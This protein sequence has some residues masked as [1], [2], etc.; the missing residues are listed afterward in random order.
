MTISFK[1]I[2]KL[3]W[4]IFIA[5]IGVF[6]LSL[7]DSLMLAHSNAQHLGLQS[8]G[9][10]PITIVLMIVNGLVQGTL[11]AAAEYY[12]QEKYLEVGAIFRNSIKL[13]LYLSLIAIPLFLLAHPIL[14]LLNYPSDQNIAAARVMK[15]LSL[16]IPFSL[17]YFVCMFFLNGVQKPRIATEF[18]IIANLLNAFLNWLLIEGN[19]GFPAMYSSGVALSTTI[20]RIFLSI[21]LLL[22]ILFLPQFKKFNIIHGKTIVPPKNQQLLG[23]SA[24]INLLSFEIG[25]AFCLFFASH[26][27]LIPAAAFT[28]SYRIIAMTHLISVSFAVAASTYIAPLQN[29]SQAMSPIIKTTF[30]LNNLIIIPLVLL[31]I[32]ATYPLSQILSNDTNLQKLMSNY[33]PFVF[34]VVFFRCLNSIQIIILRTIYDLLIPSLIYFISFTIIQP[35]SVFIIGDWK[36][37]AGIIISLMVSNIIAVLVLNYRLSPKQLYKKNNFRQNTIDQHLIL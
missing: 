3:F 31:G 19:W 37:G 4:P 24:T 29:H 10:T 13:A 30:F 27:G 1:S 17:I 26:I 22:S 7:V 23:I 18:I 11:F 32:A 33:L 21:G 36:L 6:T 28:L 15:I 35:A 25:I 8:I 16:S 14:A 9:D 12:G 34:I 5:N 2:L 20:V